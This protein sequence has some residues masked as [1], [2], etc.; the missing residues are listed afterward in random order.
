MGYKNPV[1]WSAWVCLGPFQMWGEVKRY[2]APYSANNFCNFLRGEGDFCPDAS[3]SVLESLVL[4]VSPSSPVS[5]LAQ[6]LFNSLAL[7]KAADW[8]DGLYNLLS[9]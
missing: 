2:R 6:T 1:M 8:C 5:V 3:S 7:S 9:T 4:A